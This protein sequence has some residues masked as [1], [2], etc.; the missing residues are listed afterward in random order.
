MRIRSVAVV[1]AMGGTISCSSKEELGAPERSLEA[2]PLPADPAAVAEKWIRRSDYLVDRRRE[3]PLPK[4]SAAP[5]ARESLDRAV[6][7]L[8]SREW[9]VLTREDAERFAGV[10]ITGSEEGV[11]VLLRGVELLP[12]DPKDFLCPD[13]FKVYFKDGSVRVETKGSRFADR[14]Y[15]PRPAIA[16]LPTEP[17]ELFVDPLYVRVMHSLWDESGDSPGDR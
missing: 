12:D 16:R 11:Y 15:S 7:L 3:K 2:P 4:E 1:I 13:S 10:P 8:D 5:V 6:E 14:D 17:K 9:C